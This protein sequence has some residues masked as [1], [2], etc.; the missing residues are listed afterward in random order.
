MTWLCYQSLGKTDLFCF[1]SWSSFLSTSH[2]SLDNY[3]VSP[4]KT[5]FS[6]KKLINSSHWSLWL[7]GSKLGVLYWY[8]KH[9][10]VSDKALDKQMKLRDFRYQSWGTFLI[11]L[12]I[13]PYRQ[14]PT[15]IT[16]FAGS[17]KRHWGS[18]KGWDIASTFKNS[19][20]KRGSE[21]ESV[22]HSFIVPIHKY[23]VHMPPHDYVPP[24]SKDFSRIWN[25]LYFMILTLL[26]N[27]L[28]PATLVSVLPYFYAEVR[29]SQRRDSLSHATCYCNATSRMETW[30]LPI[31]VDMVR[32]MRGDSCWFWVDPNG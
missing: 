25:C 16:K 3:W 11:C 22:L 10:S 12:E 31:M 24:G 1:G 18:Q 26:L 29:G 17:I 4:I 13:S 5:E 30:P 20:A 21:Y 32:G 8:N 19:R 15:T 2:P 27:W 9:N 23:R 28:L 7:T 6:R 14:E